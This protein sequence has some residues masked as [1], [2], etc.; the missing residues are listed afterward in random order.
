MNSVSTIFDKW[1][2]S[3][4]PFIKD[5]Q[6]IQT[7]ILQFEIDYGFKIEVDIKPI[8]VS[9]GRNLSAGAVEELFNMQDKANKYSKKRFK[10][11][12]SGYILF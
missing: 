1:A 8:E 7:L 2:K 9:K 10:S 12:Q 4:E 3:N 6:K 11:N 5:L